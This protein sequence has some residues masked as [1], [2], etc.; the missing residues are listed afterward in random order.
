MKIESIKC[1]ALRDAIIGMQVST[2]M[3][4]YGYFALYFDFIEDN[5][6]KAA[7]GVTIRGKKLLFYY[8][9][10][11]V[12]QMANKLGNDFLSFLVIHECQHILLSHITR[13]GDRNQKLSNIVQDMIINLGIKQEYGFN[14]DDFFYADKKYN[15]NPIKFDPKEYAKQQ[16]NGIIFE[17]MYAYILENTPPQ[18]GEGD[19]DEDSDGEGNGGSSGSSGDE[20]SSDG[21][22]G[23][24]GNKKSKAEGQLVDD[25]IMNKDSESGTLND[26]EIA[27]MEAM[28]REIHE[29]LKARGFNP[30][31]IIGENFEYKRGKSIVNVFRKV[32]GNGTLKDKTYRHLSRRCPGLKGNRKDN[33]DINIILDTSGSLYNELDEYINLVVGKFS[34]YVVQ[35]DTR[36][37]WDGHLKT[38]ADWKKVKKCGGGGTILQP[39]IDKL[40]ELKRQNYPLYFVSDFY[41]ESL[42]LS[43]YKGP[44]IFIKSKGSTNPVWTGSKQVKTISSCRD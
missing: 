7:A 26:S 8:N 38:M 19:D 3:N 25:H 14:F 13:T 5:T 43:K 27:Q 17:P 2:K 9:S 22:K 29:N 32:F 36:V 24:K 4:Y 30:G 10:I 1:E 41:C 42:D 23:S 35:V 18:S 16:F 15:G 34:S 40:I 33:R 21:S 39:G 28:V 20:D 12:D 37:V 6:L 44:V 31:K 11:L